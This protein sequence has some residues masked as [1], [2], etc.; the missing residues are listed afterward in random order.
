[1]SIRFQHLVLSLAISLV[2]TAAAACRG[3]SAPT[4]PGPDGVLPAEVSG[5]VRD[6]L[7]GRP[8]ADALVTTAIARALTDR[9]GRFSV[10][11]PRGRTR[12]HVAHTQ[13]ALKSFDAYAEPGAGLTLEIAP[14]G[15][16]VLGCEVRQGVMWMLVVDLQGRKTIVRR[17]SSGVTLGD[18]AARRWV[19]AHEFTWW[20]LDE[21]TWLVDGPPASHAEVGTAEWWLFDTDGNVRRHGCGGDAVPVRGESGGGDDGGEIG[22]A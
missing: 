19:V 6:S 15:P 13:Y 4:A 2:A 16:V 21:L 1:M 10:L 20:A 8:V 7:G 12:I 11:A 18:G 5:S 22:P 9:D 14:L 17:D 3:D